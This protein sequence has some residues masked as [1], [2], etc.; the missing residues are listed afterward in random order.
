[1]DSGKE[2]I[3]KLFQKQRV[4]EAEIHFY[5]ARCR[6][7]PC[8]ETEALRRRIQDVQCMLE[9]IKGFYLVISEDE[10]IVIKRHLVDAID[11]PRI[12]VEYEQRWGK[13]Y[14]KSERT[15]IYYQTRALD[16]IAS[17]VAK[18]EDTYDFSWLSNF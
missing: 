2:R 11:W 17:F 3:K 1:M 12:T 7:R 5:N 16:K 6:M 18:H 15:M 10:A 14:A 4:L 9:G 13:D 8:E